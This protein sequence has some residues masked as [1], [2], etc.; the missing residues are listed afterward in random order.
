MVKNNPD[1]PWHWYLITCNCF[2]Y[3]KNT[4]CNK[5]NKTILL[6]SILKQKQLKLNN[7]IK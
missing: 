1:E 5:Y 2:E 3:D 7:K 6:S 4:Y